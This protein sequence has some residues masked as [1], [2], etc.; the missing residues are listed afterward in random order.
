MR[1]ATERY[2]GPI[3]SNIL[4][5]TLSQP[6]DKEIDPLQS[7]NRAIGSLHIENIGNIDH[8]VRAKMGGIPVP[9]VNGTNGCGSSRTIHE[10]EG[11]TNSST[12]P[13]DCVPGISGSVQ[14]DESTDETP[15]ESKKLKS[16][17]IPNDYLCPISLE[18]MRD[19][20]IVATGQ[21]IT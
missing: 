14:E 17:V 4:A 2:G 16:P 20:V 6:L 5:R 15:E 19:P 18:L 8:E 21:V 10:S 3:N 9:L 11:V 1:R 13:E 7:S 12:S